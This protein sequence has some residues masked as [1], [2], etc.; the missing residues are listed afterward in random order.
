MH[1]SIDIDECGVENGGCS[2]TC[3]NAL[4]SHSCTCPAGMNLHPDARTCGGKYRILYPL[5]DAWNSFF[6]DTTPKLDIKLLLLMVKAPKCVCFPFQLTDD[7]TEYRHQS[8][9]F[10]LKL[11]S[12]Q[13]VWTRNL[14]RS[15]NLK[16]KYR[17]AFG[18]SCYMLGKQ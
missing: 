14:Q 3:V 12:L 1:A 2:H 11:L 16:V 4:Y 15:S 8:G 6:S 5:S 13:P 7:G 17:H 9:L 10:V 18:M